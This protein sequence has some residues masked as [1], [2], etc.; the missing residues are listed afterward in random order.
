MPDNNND[1]PD[2]MPLWLLPQFNE[3]TTIDTP[4]DDGTT[5]SDADSHTSAAPAQHRSNHTAAGLLSAAGHTNV[6]TSA[7][8]PTAAPPSTHV[9]GVLTAQ[10]R[11]RLVRT[12][13]GAVTDDL[14]A[15][16]SDRRSQIDDPK[17]PN[18][19]LA[20]YT[21]DEERE[22]V[23][24]FIVDQMQ[25]Y[26]NA[27]ITAGQQAFPVDEQ[28]SIE[29]SIFDTICGLG[30]I[31]AIVE[32]PDVEDIFIHGTRCHS[33]DP[34]GVKTYH[35]EIA[36]TD[37]EVIEWIT[38]LAQRASGGGRLFSQMHPHVRLNLEGGIRFTADAWTVPRPA[39]AIR[40]HRHKNV[41]LDDC[42]K[43]KTMPPLLAR[44]FATGE[45]GG[46]SMVA[47]GDM[48]SGKT[49]HIRAIANSLP[50]GT[51]IGTV[52][53]ERELFLHELDG[54]RDDVVS[55]EILTGGGEIDAKSG[56]QLGSVGLGAMMYSAVRHRLD[57]LMV[58][59]VAGLE[60]IHM[61]KAMQFT[62]G[63][64]ST[65]HARTARGAID[66][67]V[68]CATED[69]TVTEGYATRQ[70]AFHINLIFH[71]EIDISHDENGNQTKQRYVDEV[72]YLEPGENGEPA[73]T[74]IYKGKAGG[75][76]QFGSFPPA[77][78]KQLRAGGFTDTEIPPN[79]L[80]W[81]EAS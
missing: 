32:L 54:R 40:M 2:R 13:V 21:D 52:E 62:K 69:H 41:T 7:G 23:R 79:S 3:P 61:L 56:K 33:V 75:I 8:P 12:L 53:T 64:L 15:A 35:S 81:D 74:T 47:A 44:I 22:L 66:R 16:M 46:M 14:T 43:M 4:S 28:H 51:R 55:Y 30:P 1:A 5:P 18:K 39:V 36:D 26:I 68:T 71:L 65:T 63:S 67:L 11:R 80:E 9:A 57:R 73:T 38:N 31:Q 24:R 49:M 78:L 48:G 58:G 29:K 70:V 10:E 37:E 42:V 77:M 25:R 19:D 76:G 72:I 27:T 59:E 17:N 6:A 45:R 20:P 34:E 60:I 50:L